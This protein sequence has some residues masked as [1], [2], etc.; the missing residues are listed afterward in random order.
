MP[1]TLSVKRSVV[2]ERTGDELASSPV[3]GSCV[4]TSAE[5]ALRAALSG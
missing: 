1:E 2:S 3:V 5:R 4:L